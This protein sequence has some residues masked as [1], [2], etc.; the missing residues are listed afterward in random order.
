[1][2]LTQIGVVLLCIPAK[3]WRKAN[4]LDNDEAEIL[5]DSLK[6]YNG[7]FLNRH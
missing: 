1:L 5:R 4:V 3:D 7:Y 2:V 6:M